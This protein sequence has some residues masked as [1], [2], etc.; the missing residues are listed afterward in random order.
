MYTFKL[1]VV[2]IGPD[3]RHRTDVLFGRNGCLSIYMHLHLLIPGFPPRRGRKFLIF[4]EV[5]Y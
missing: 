1:G 3:V 5:E 2:C 4:Y